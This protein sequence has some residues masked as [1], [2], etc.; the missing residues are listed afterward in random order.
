M[1]V[2]LICLFELEYPDEVA[3]SVYEP[4]AGDKPAERGR[5]MA[6]VES[7][8]SSSGVFPVYLQGMAAIEEEL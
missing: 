5:G 4:A 6:A 1:S 8:R 7:W 2:L 3:M